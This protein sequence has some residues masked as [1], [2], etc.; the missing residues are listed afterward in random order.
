MVQLLRVLTDLPEATIDEIMMEHAKHPE[1]REAQQ[2]LAGRCNQICVLLE[3]L[4]LSTRSAED[5]QKAKRC[6][7]VLYGT[8]EELKEDMI[9]DIMDELPLEVLD[10]TMMSGKSITD[11][12]VTLN[13]ADSKSM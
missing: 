2:I 3:E 7:D 4:F 11:Y 9:R 8:Q 12:L 1:K 6:A 10:A 5:L 13:F